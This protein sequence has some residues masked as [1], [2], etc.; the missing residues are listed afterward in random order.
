MQSVN[1]KFEVEIEVYPEGKLL[2]VEIGSSSITVSELMELL[3]KL[4]IPRSKYV[5]AT[6][7]RALLDEER[8][9]AG[10]R[11][12]LLPLVMGGAGPLVGTLFSLL[13]P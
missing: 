4:G 6:G 12:L 9:F 11:L 10:T 1:R 13:I 5:L 7:G 2:K 3:E 8:V